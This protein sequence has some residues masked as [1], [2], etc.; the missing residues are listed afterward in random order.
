MG[1]FLL[2]EPQAQIVQHSRDAG[3]YRVSQLAQQGGYGRLRKLP[4]Q[5]VP[6][7]YQQKLPALAGAENGKPD[8]CPCQGLVVLVRYPGKLRIVRKRAGKQ[9]GRLNAGQGWGAE[10]R[11]IFFKLFLEITSAVL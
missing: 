9:I 8:F 3:L 2:P 5:A 4:F 11:Q 7:V 1:K 6:S 10:K